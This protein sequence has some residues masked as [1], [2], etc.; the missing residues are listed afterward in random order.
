[1]PAGRS[2]DHLVRPQHRN[3]ERERRADA[4]LALEPDAT[5]VKL[6]EL[7]RQRET[8]AGAFDLLVRCSDLPELFEHRVLI[9]GRNTDPGV[10]HR[11]LDEA[12][13]RPRLDSYPASF[14]GELDRVRQQVRDDLPDLS[15][16][17]VNL[18]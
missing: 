13:H 10:A 15:L 11:H 5:M 6:D 8:E 2:L 17:G 12:V 3:R 9:L 16:I 4:D 7:A 14:R 1:M 18:A